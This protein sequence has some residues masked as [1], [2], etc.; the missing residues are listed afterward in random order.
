M[1]SSLLGAARVDRLAQALRQDAATLVVGLR[2]YVRYLLPVAAAT[3]RCIRVLDPQQQAKIDGVDSLAR[4]TALELVVRL[5]ALVSR[6]EE[7]GIQLDLGV[8]R[9]SELAELP[10]PYGR[11]ARSTDRAVSNESAEIL[12]RLSA[13]LTRKVRGAR[14]ALA[15]S[16]D[17]VSQAANSVLELVDRMLRN[18]FTAEYVLEWIDR[19]FPTPRDDL[20]QLHG[21]KRRP[22]TRGRA[23]CFIYAGEN[24]V[25]TTIIHELAVEAIVAVRPRLQR[26]KHADS[27]TDGE[28]EELVALL[29]AVEACMVLASRVTWLG[30]E[31]SSL[32]ELRD[33][34]VLSA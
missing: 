21:R 32:G 34:L 9:P 16:A 30:V 3:D 28:R 4:S 8:A 14:D 33:R 29:E 6:F 23:L 31:D 18:A 10:G 13:G 12:E 17:P 27:C 20:I 7:A 11:I 1:L 15:F 26:L 24:P 25:E 22:S 5:D 19:C 2:R